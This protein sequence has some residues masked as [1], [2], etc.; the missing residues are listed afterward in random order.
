VEAKLS[1]LRTILGE[2]GSVLVAYSGGA[3]STLLLR[4]AR[5][6]LGDRVVAVTARSP[7]YPDREYEEGLRLA[8]D[9]GVK[10]LTVTT[11]ELDQSRFSENP[12]HR[13]Y[14][15]KRELFLKLR[16]IAAQEGLEWVADGA[17][18]DDL[19]DHRPGRMAAEELGVRSPLC[20]AK[21]TKADVRGISRELGLATWNK[22]AQ[23]CLASRV[24]YGRAI[25]ASMLERISRAEDYLHSLGMLNVRVRD[26]G[27]TARIE[28]D[29]ASVGSLVDR[30]LRPRIVEFLKSLGY[31]YVTA[32]LEGYRTG[33]MNEV[34]H[35]EH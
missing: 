1:D 34:L 21:L 13:C 2:M 25:N 17:N 28:V 4:V 12:P 15:C 11:G 20:E 6:V 7:I 33:S 26:H 35:L 22:P 19:Q 31:T 8:G 5:D 3:D 30:D 10:H 18:H 29:T 16:D 24:P 27:D 23:A 9:M 14:Y 32:D